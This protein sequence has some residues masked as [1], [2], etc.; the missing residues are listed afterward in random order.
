MTL[1]TVFRVTLA[2]S[3][4]A[5]TPC[6]MAQGAGKSKPPADSVFDEPASDRA[7]PDPLAEEDKNGS[8]PLAPGAAE[9]PSE[10]SPL[11]ALLG[12][13]PVSEQIL[14]RLASLSGRPD[15]REDVSGLIAYYK[16]A[17]GRPIWSDSDGFSQNALRAVKEIRSADDWGLDSSAFQPPANPEKDASAAALADAEIKLSLAVLKYARH[18]RGGRL[19]PPSISDIIDRH[20]RVYDPKSVLR[21]IAAADSAD[22]YLRGLHPK[23]EQFKRLRQALLSL[24]KSGGG[25]AATTSAERIPSG[26]AFRPGDTDPQ[27]ALI[28]KRLGADASD[29]YDYFDTPLVEAVNRY[30]K[31]HGLQPTGIIDKKL[32]ASLNEGV[33]AAA[34]PATPDEK[35]MRILVNMER[36][37][38]MPDDLGEF[39]VWNSIPEQLTRVFDRG[40][41]TLQERIVVGKPVT[42]TPTFSANMQFVTFNPEWG[43]PDG[44]KEKELGPKLRRAG[45]GRGGDEDFFSFGGRSSGGSRQV[46][47]RMGGLR[48]TYN[49]R[50]VDPDSVNWSSV[51]IKRYQ[52][53]QGAGPRNVLGVV[54]F[55]FPNKHDVYM[56]DTPDRH[57]FGASQRAFSHGCMRTQNPLHLAEVVLAHDKGWSQSQVQEAVQTGA[58]NEVKLS[59]RV[60]VHIVYFT[61]EVDEQGQLRAF[62]DIYGLDGKVASA[63]SGRTV[64]F[65]NEPV[66]TAENKPRTRPDDEGP[67]WDT[68][69]PREEPNSDRQ[70]AASREQAYGDRRDPYA[71]REQAYGDRRDPYASRQDP[72]GRSRFRLFGR[73]L[74][75][76]EDWN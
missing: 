41:V 23:H 32:R 57:F 62:P 35:R 8:A 18:A 64:R 28:R 38:W 27:I 75:P 25:D 14:S 24:S 6:A 43:V 31:D 67:A 21:G 73:S 29:S 76:F 68:Y 71:S 69:A 20:P 12:G 46:L 58:T 2:V 52:F 1:T 39:Y 16:E 65:V 36:W 4:A 40:R 45:G 34:T 49:G 55:R 54:K 50:E 33:G 48:V 30:Q 66:V 53:I 72:N 47:Q 37:R 59:T 5:L 13:D 56:H 17:K 7:A 51:D 74:N 22:A 15:A 63:L 60:P 61:A 11:G 42:P 10:S 3:L 26:P 9:R 19:D 70:D 44:I